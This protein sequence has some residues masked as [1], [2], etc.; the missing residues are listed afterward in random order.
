MTEQPDENDATRDHDSPSQ[1]QGQSTVSDDATIAR[2]VADA[3][4][5]DSDPS[6]DGTRS[7]TREHQT[8]I[9][10]DS[11]GT[12]DQKATSGEAGSV[13]SSSHETDDQTDNRT[14]ANAPSVTSPG[15]A[16][17]RRQT[18]LPERIAGYKTIQR[19]GEGSFGIVI[20]CQD[21]K[22][23]RAVA[24]KL[25][26]ANPLKSA[27][28]I[29]RFLKE[30]RAA[31]HLRHP[32]IIPVYEYGEFGGNPY[33]VYEFVDGVTLDDWIEQHTD[34]RRRI[35]LLA[36]IAQALEYAHSLGIIHRDIKPANILI[37]HEHSQPHIADFGCAKQDRPDQLQTV[38]GSMMGT[39]AYMSPEVCQGYANQADARSDIWAL[40]VILYETLTGQRPFHGKF[41]EL[42]QQIQST[43]P[44][45]PTRIDSSLPGD[46][47]TITLKC[48][49][50]K[51]ERRFQSCGELA[52][53]L[54]AWLDN[55]PIKA[56][57]VGVIERTWLW[58]RRNP[59]VASLLGLVAA[60]LILIAIG[61]MLYSINTR[62]QNEAILKKQRQIVQA[63]ID[64]LV[65]ASPEVLPTLIEDMADLDPDSAKEIRR[66]LAAQNGSPAEGFSYNLALYQLAKASGESDV[67]VMEGLA[68]YVPLGTAAEHVAL[69]QVT[70]MDLASYSPS[71]WKIALDESTTPRQRM[72]VCGVLATTDPTNAHWQDQ[73]AESVRFLLLT[74]SAE[75]PNWCQLLRPVSASLKP[76][77]Q[78]VLRTGDA[79]VQQKAVEIVSWLF[80]DDLSFLLGLGLELPPALLKQLGRNLEQHRVPFLALLDEQEAVPDPGNHRR[81]TNARLIRGLL[82]EPD[83]LHR[84][85]H[86]WTGPISDESRNRLVNEATLAG[87]SP[88]GFIHWITEDSPELTKPKSPILVAAILALGQANQQQL[89]QTRREN[90]RLRL[91]FLFRQHKDVAVHSAC[92]WLL[93][94]WGFEPD[95]HDALSEI[96]TRQPKPGYS[97]H[98]DVTGICFAVFQ[99]VDSF[100]YGPPADYP[101]L[102]YDNFVSGE[103][104]LTRRFGIAIHETTDQQFMTWEQLTIDAYLKMSDEASQN[105][106]DE[107]ESRSAKA[108]LQ[109]AKRLQRARSGRIR[110]IAD[111]FKA[112]AGQAAIDVSQSTR[113]VT[114]I[115]W[116]T[117]AFFCNGMSQLAGIPP[118]Q[119]VYKIVGSASWQASAVEEPLAKFGYRLPTGIEWEFACRANSDTRFFFGD[120]IDLA[121]HYLWSVENSKNLL[122]PVGH[123]KPNSNGLFDAQGNASEWCH[124]PFDYD[125]KI[126]SARIFREIRGQSTVEQA[127]KMTVFYRQ[128]S[129][130]SEFGSR[131][132]FRLARTYP[133]EN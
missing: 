46:L 31:G 118:D 54:Q 30:A 35:R 67:R 100:H 99:P 21:E 9:D 124:S 95:I 81:Q 5:R 114:R 96:Q 129:T 73:I 123:L 115:N 109:R 41:S 82:A 6:V 74:R 59:T 94:R 88:A 76:E 84:V 127:S 39:P 25:Q 83:Q 75:L 10:P 48:I 66:L 106:P 89:F 133:P 107:A 33:I 122:Q 119:H 28:R 26:K 108:L 49:E 63:R 24:I 110:S 111:E 126:E 80:Q 97:W 42:F 38:D 93:T 64:G 40:G 4:S 32:N 72:L 29:D 86:S 105:N 78:R 47:E 90:L 53:D 51:P 57:R 45:R 7:L 116:D 101:H 62:R 103:A 8:E 92:L 15:Q 113:P 61:S 60:C 58:S 12:L 52:G 77:L 18:S 121:T 132:G 117:A 16:T 22:L 70:G 65:T 1:S 19:L 3:N 130:P 34:L 98:E 87:L 120:S 79:Q 43:E 56:R 128:E 104:N 68:E 44:K 20:K 112:D 13:A 27:N 2:Q 23:D 102:P 36:D 131:R 11:D 91:L 69:L 85:V 55:R 37:D 17:R 14:N 125:S 50:K 71:F